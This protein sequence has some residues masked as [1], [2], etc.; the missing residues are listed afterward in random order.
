MTPADGGPRAAPLL[1]TPRLRL[2]PPRAEDAAAFG[3][4]FAEARAEGEDAPGPDEAAEWIAEQAGA[5]SA[6]GAFGA[7]AIVP[8][9]DEAAGLCGLA[10]VRGRPGE[11]RLVLRLSHAARGRGWGREAAGAVLV[12]GFLVMAL[13]R[14]TAAADPSDIP[15]IRALEAVGLRLAGLEVPPG[16]GPP[17]QL[18][19]LERPV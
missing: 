1:D 3:A 10:P 17:R 9:G 13:T 14:V 2:R 18:Y 15:A 7:L 8:R 19:A 5:L 4:L 16:G 11:A 6:P 12:H